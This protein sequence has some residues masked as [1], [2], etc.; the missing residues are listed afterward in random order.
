MKKKK[1]N[2]QSQQVTY[3]VIL[4]VHLVYQATQATISPVSSPIS[5]A[6]HHCDTSTIDSLLINR[7]ALLQVQFSFFCRGDVPKHS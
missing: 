4:A 5:H 2:F 6:A 7:Y 3:P 1:K